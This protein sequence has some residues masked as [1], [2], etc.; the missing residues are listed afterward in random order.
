MSSV[1]WNRK[2]PDRMSEA[3]KRF[4]EKHPNYCRDYSRKQRER[5]PDYLRKYIKEYAK[6]HP[7]IIKPIR[8]HAR[9][10]WRKNNRHKTRV[11]NLVYNYPN[12]YPLDD[13]CAFCQATE[14]LEHGHLDYEDDGQNYLTVCHACNCW[15][16]KTIELTE[17][18]TAS[19]TKN[20]E[21]GKFCWSNPPCSH[22]QIED[23]HLG[24]ICCV[25]PEYGTFYEGKKE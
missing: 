12:R 9:K 22:I 11:F 19:T 8:S 21:K 6:K 15:M 7:E 4:R 20:C 1:E 25:Y 2:H 14:K 3:Q 24:S 23:P 5:K 13:K 10:K 16:D 18:S 17:M